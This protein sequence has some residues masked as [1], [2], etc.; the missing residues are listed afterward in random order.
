[1]SSW[2]AEGKSGGEEICPRNGNLSF[3]VPCPLPPVIQTCV[4]VRFQDMFYSFVIWSCATPEELPG[5]LFLGEEANSAN[6]F[7]PSA[8][9]HMEKIA[10][11]ERYGTAGK[12][13]C[14]GGEG[15]RECGVKIKPQIATFLLR[16]WT[17]PP[18]PPPPKKPRWSP[19]KLCRAPSVAGWNGGICFLHWVTSPWLNNPG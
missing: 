6:V 4:Q 18:P 7:R 17:F 19:N 16:H 9:E 15:Q 8:T 11:I 13:F 2:K 3:N 1:M 5:M 14:L 10:I 12:T